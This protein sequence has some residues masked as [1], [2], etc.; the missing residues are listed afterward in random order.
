MTIAV[1]F[2]LIL[3]AGHGVLLMNGAPKLIGLLNG[4][5]TGVLLFII[6]T[7]AL[8]TLSYAVGVDMNS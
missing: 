3:A 1:V 6:G 4:H 5:E 2:Q 8:N 7:D